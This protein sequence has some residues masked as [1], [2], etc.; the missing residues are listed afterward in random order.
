M[1]LVNKVL[2]DCVGNTYLKELDDMPTTV[3]I[4]LKGV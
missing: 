2:K 1:V 3:V 4:K